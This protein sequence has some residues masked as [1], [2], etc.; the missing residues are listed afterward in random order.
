[1]S[2]RPDPARVV[3]TLL[4]FHGKEQKDLVPVLNLSQSNIS[5]LLSKEHPSRALRT[6]EIFKLAEYFDVT[7]NVLLE[8]AEDLVRSK[9]SPRELVSA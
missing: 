7:Y 6:D 4:A 3:R 5:G 8:D 2:Y 9:C 1:M